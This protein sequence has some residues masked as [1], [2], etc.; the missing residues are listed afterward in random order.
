MAQ[1]KKKRDAE[2]EDFALAQ[3]MV[4][5]LLDVGKTFVKRMI[6]H[7]NQHGKPVTKQ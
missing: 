1:T 3:D 4:D 6:G 2:G 5:V 7:T